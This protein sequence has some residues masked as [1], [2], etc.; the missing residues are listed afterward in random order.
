MF[1][2]SM[3]L[4][5]CRIRTEFKYDTPKYVI[6]YNS[7]K[8]R[9]LVKNLFQTVEYCKIALASEFRYIKNS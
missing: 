2:L 8:I 7:Q 3:Y 4:S 1:V 6:N 5:V 9:S